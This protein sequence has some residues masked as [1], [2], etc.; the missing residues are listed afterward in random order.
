MHEDNNSRKGKANDK[1][2]GRMELLPS[3]EAG[4]GLD[5][6][7]INNRIRLTR[8]GVNAGIE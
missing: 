5:F 6:L 1:W 3:A 8:A 2:L 7:W 4:F